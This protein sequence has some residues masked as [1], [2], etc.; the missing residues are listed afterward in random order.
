MYWASFRVFGIKA[1]VRCTGKGSRDPKRPLV[2]IEKTPSPEETG[3][4]RIK[5]ALKLIKDGMEGGF[6]PIRSRSGGE[7]GKSR[8]K[9]FGFSLL[10]LTTP[11]V[12]E[13]NFGF[14]ANTN[15]LN[16]SLR[17]S[18]VLTSIDHPS[19]EYCFWTKKTYYQSVSMLNSFPTNS[20]QEA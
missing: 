2:P 5:S 4:V 19:N 12:S 8:S 14:W 11:P 10:D 9:I 18:I 17:L 1:I 7:G 20:V 15:D 13:I 3:E 16:F 6:S